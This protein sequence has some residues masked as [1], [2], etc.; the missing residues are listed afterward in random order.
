MSDLRRKQESDMKEPLPGRLPTVAF[1][2]TPDVQSHLAELVATGVK[3]A[4]TS[5]LAAYQAEGETLPEPGE[6]ATVVDGAGQPVCT[7]RTTLVEIRR[8]ADIDADHACAE[9]EGDRTVQGWQAAHQ[10]FL[11][12]VCASLGIT[13]DDELEL[14]LET[15]QVIDPAASVTTP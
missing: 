13:F 14:V 6:L 10:P 9:G 5:V 15:F 11:A 4:T 7:I 3:R 8:Y 1:G 2:T 12:E